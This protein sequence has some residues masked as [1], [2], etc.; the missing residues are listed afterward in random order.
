M[1]RTHKLDG[2]STYVVT[3]LDKP[4][5]RVQSY[6]VLDIIFTENLTWNE[7]VNKMTQSCNHIIQTLRHFKRSAPYNI[8]KKLPS[9][10]TGT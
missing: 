10:S 5:E 6:K 7:H 9:R 8:R 4:L 2:V 1:S 3:A